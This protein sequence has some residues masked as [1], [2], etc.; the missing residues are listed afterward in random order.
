MQ[1][2]KQWNRKTYEQNMTP[3]MT[4]PC[5]DSCEYAKQT[6]HD[7]IVMSWDGSQG[8]PGHGERHGCIKEY[9]LASLSAMDK[10]ATIKQRA[11]K[12]QTPT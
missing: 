3:R 12:G 9:K 2:D 8:D 10:Q 6:Q 1:S 11:N 4:K 7:Y 5:E